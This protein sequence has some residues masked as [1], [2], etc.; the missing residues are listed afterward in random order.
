MVGNCDRTHPLGKHCKTHGG[1]VLLAHRWIP[2]KGPVIIRKAFPYHDVVIR[3]YDTQTET[4]MES[5]LTDIILSIQTAHSISYLV[6]Y[7]WVVIVICIVPFMF[8]FNFK[9]NSTLM[10]EQPLMAKLV[11]QQRWQMI[12]YFRQ[13]ISISR[14]ILSKR[15]ICVR[16]GDQGERYMAEVSGLVMI[17]YCIVRRSHIL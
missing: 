6:I 16:R 2:K 11:H 4:V 10:C 9:M 14:Q 13:C 5:L 7:K 12:T 1:S 3:R 8:D 15:C 17:T